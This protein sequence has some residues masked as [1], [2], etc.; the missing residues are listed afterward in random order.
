MA[1]QPSY[2]GSLEVCRA[3]A[4]S[5]DGRI[6]SQGKETLRFRFDSPPFSHF[7][8]AAK[9]TKPLFFADRYRGFF[10]QLADGQMDY[11]WLH[12]KSLSKRLNLSEEE[13]DGVR[14][15]DFVRI[16]QDKFLLQSEEEAPSEKLT[17]LISRTVAISNKLKSWPEIAAVARQQRRG[18]HLSKERYHL[19]NAWDVTETGV[20]ARNRDEQL[21]KGS[22]T[23]VTV[24]VSLDHEWLARRML[25]ETDLA[26]RVF[27]IWK[28]FAGKRGILDT[29]GTLV[30]LDEEYREIAVS[31][32][33]RF[34]QNLS[35]RSPICIEKSCKEVVHDLLIGL[36]TLAKD[37]MHGDL[38]SKNLLTRWNVKKNKQEAAI[39]DLDSFTFY[40][41]G[42]GSLF[43]YDVSCPE[44]MRIAKSR[45]VV[46]APNPI[47][48]V[49]PMGLILFEILQLSTK[50]SK[51]RVP[52]PWRQKPHR[53]DIE[54]PE[55]I[56]ELTKTHHRQDKIDAMI[57]RA[58]F[59]LPFT[60]LLKEM[61]QVDP[62]Q[63]WTAERAL[64]YFE[65]FCEN[66]PIY[67][68][69][70]WPFFRNEG[71]SGYVASS[72]LYKALSSPPSPPNHA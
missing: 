51:S 68:E 3:P 37:G 16:A 18:F 46:T 14:W 44:M 9:R 35:T 26:A 45:T 30:Y 58:G 17:P 43:I 38:Y 24:V 23:R 36:A 11:V 5:L 19:E 54:N 53:Y 57:D 6:I 63:R 71:D 1:I 28:H 32:H 39:C 56:H 4:I 48:E 69:R 50:D 13:M 22:Y 21:G 52:L 33:P 60:R 65:S 61:L 59:T 8:I 10:V 31:L 66:G 62:K 27:R 67:P 70:V 64:Q 12:R 7:Q 41:E 29:L 72:P 34:D 49:W 55:D 15:K 2:C 40:H 42:N 25:Y 47:H 20:V